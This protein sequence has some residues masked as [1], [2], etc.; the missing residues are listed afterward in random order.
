MKTTTKRQKSGTRRGR[1][2]PN[3]REQGK[4]FSSEYQPEK[5]GRPKN[6]F[7]YLVGQY[8]ISREDIEALLMELSSLSKSDLQRVKTDPNTPAVRAII[9]SALLRDNKNGSIYSVEFLLDRLFG[10]AVQKMETVVNINT[11]DEK[12]Q[13]VLK[14]FG[15]N[16]PDTKD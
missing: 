2:N 9:A 16:K 4:R 7:R 5:N 12:V 6:V 11:D 14:E 8:A 15:V 10:R 13:Q 3:I 1:G